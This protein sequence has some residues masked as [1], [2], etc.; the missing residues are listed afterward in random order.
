[1]KYSII[2]Y[3]YYVLPMPGH[4]VELEKKAETLEN[5]S[6]I[7][8]QKKNF[9]STVALLEE[10]KAI[11][12]QLRFHGK[13]GMLNQRISRVRN[14]LKR[15]IQGIT[16]RTKSEQDFQKRVEKVLSEKQ[17]MQEKQHAQQ[18]LLPPEM[19]KNLEKVNM[20]LEKAAREE[21]L[22]KTPRVI[23][24]YEYILE[25]YKSIPKDSLDLSEKIAEIE[26][27]IALLRT[28]M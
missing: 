19:R 10:A 11:Y 7:E 4:Y 21:G 18:T 28:K 23:G 6:K 2:N 3:Q 8:F 16:V 5:Q 9:S 14:L 1:M 26:N 20:L 17:R 25:L 27:K 12:S 24:R 15:E 13:I 22:G